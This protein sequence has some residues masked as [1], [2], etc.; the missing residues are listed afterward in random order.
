MI[1]IFSIVDLTKISKPSRNKLCNCIPQCERGVT[2][3]TYNDGMMLCWNNVINMQHELNHLI[4]SSGNYT[5]WTKEEEQFII[6]YMREND[7]K[8]GFKKEIA[9]ALKKSHAQ[10]KVK[11]G[12]MKKKGL[13]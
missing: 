8:Y 13:L 12:R 1:P 2:L 9:K 6:S 4:G 11:I 10:V 5:K 7:C 3:T